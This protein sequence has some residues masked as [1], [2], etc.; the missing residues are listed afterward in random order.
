M[1]ENHAAYDTSATN[2][3][4]CTYAGEAA[5]SLPTSGRCDA[6]GPAGDNGGDEGVSDAGGP[7]EGVAAAPPREAIENFAR[8]RRWRTRARAKHCHPMLLEPPGALLP[9][10]NRPTSAARAQQALP[11]GTDFPA[12]QQPLPGRRLMGTPRITCRAVPSLSQPE[13]LAT[14]PQRPL[15]SPPRLHGA[16]SAVSAQPPPRGEP[17]ETAQLWRCIGK[18][19]PSSGMPQMSRAKK[20]TMLQSS[21]R[22]A[23]PRLPRHVRRSL[24][25]PT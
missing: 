16:W 2:A 22:Q 6:A 9:Q 20:M 7:L 17:C 24:P 14:E 1:R 12:C 18:S 3:A 8:L 10:Q 13:K 23:S 21:L 5:A 25:Q 19:L 4:R 11:K 15:D